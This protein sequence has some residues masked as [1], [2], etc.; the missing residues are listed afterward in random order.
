[1]LSSPTQGDYATLVRFA[2]A[3]G[4]LWSENRH[5]FHYPS[6]QWT[7]GEVIVDHLSIPI[8]PDAPP[9][10][11]L[12]RF[13][14]YSTSAEQM[15]PVLDGDRY[16]GTYVQLP[17]QLARATEPPHPD[18][19][20]IRTRL[21]AST[22][23]I[24]LLGANLDTTGARP[25]EQVHLTLF[26]QADSAPLRD[27]DVTLILGDAILYTGAPVHGSYP[28]SEWVA[29]EVIA[30]RYD[31][32]VPRETEPG[33]YALRLQ[34]G[35]TRINLG[36]VTVTSVD[37]SFDLPTISHPLHAAL[38]D[39]IELLGYD[40]SA[41]AAAPGDTLGLTLYWRALTEM[42]ESYTVFV[43]LVAPDGLMAGQR[44]S[45]PMD[46]TY[47][48]NLWTAGEIVTDDYEIPISASAAAGEHRLAVGMY[49]AATGERLSAT[50]SPDDSTLL[51][52]IAI[53]P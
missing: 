47:P 42:D 36:A 31:A 27:H 44:D 15:L 30:D 35:D 37:R 17:M 45:L 33:D 52:S 24:T 9:G 39:Q 2:D 19:L 21:D 12:A 23:G 16:A 10:A 6:E 43:H 13:S 1:V 46:G 14:F 11:Y 20:G 51:Q 53:G 3:W 7:P 41:E 25:G 8:A 50:D 40:L 29:G 4:F 28:T 18:D 49:I 32:R 34:I 38:G 48:T 5:A 22:D 26:W